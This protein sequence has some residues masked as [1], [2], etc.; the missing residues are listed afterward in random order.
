MN[1]EDAEVEAR[2]RNLALGGRAEPGQF[3]VEVE[4]S[5]GTWDVERREEQQEPP[6]RIAPLLDVAMEALSRVHW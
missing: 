2:R 1:R 5:D 4:R 3:W 6:S